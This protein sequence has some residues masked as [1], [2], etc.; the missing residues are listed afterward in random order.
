MNFLLLLLLSRFSRVRLCATPET[1]F[2]QV[3]LSLGFSRQE[4]WS[5]CHFLLQCMK[6]KSQSEVAQSCPRLLPTSWTVAYQAPP[7]MG[8]SGQ[9]YWSGLPL[10]SLRMNFLGHSNPFHLQLPVSTLPIPLHFSRFLFQK[11]LGCYSLPQMLLVCPFWIQLKWIPVFTLP[12]H[13]DACAC[14]I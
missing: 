9:E 1:A 12:S 5:G 2:Y 6:V 4:Q 10:P 13:S 7:S 3:P 14:A 8:F 11:D